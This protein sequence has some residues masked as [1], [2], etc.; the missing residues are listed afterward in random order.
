MRFTRDEFVMIVRRGMKFFIR[1]SLLVA[2]FSAI[3]NLK[4]MILFISLLAFFLTFIPYYV[5]K[6]YKLIVPMEIEF[7]VV[8]FIYASLFLGEVHGYYERFWWWDALLHT[9]SG[10]ALGVIGFMILFVLDKSGRIDT[11]PFWIAVFTFAFALSL[12]AG[13]EIFEFAGDQLL[14][15]N[16][17]KSGL[18]DTMWDLI[19][20]SVGGLL[21]AIGGYLYKKGDKPLLLDRMIDRFEKSNPRL[22]KK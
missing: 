4:W 8:I 6:N 11:E 9:G 19:V 7:M 18:V 14:G 17:Q 12:G 16:M 1:A 2:M 13:W 3:I 10:L 15:T 22:F 5:G 21:A 20:D